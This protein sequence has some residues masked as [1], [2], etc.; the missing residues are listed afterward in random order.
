MTTI[1]EILE[2]FETDHIVPN[3]A[4]IEFQETRLAFY[5]GALATLEVLSELKS[6]E[7]NDQYIQDFKAS[8]EEAVEIATANIGVT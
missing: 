2:Q 6:D 4:E 8:L 7:I 3:A 5:S 1:E